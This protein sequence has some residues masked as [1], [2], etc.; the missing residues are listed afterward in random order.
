MDMK[1]A[2]Y[3]STTGL[4]V[5]T[6]FLAL[7]M[8]PTLVPRTA[9]LQG[10][11]SGGALAA[12]YGLG[13]LGEALWAYLELPSAPRRVWLKL[14][15]GAAVLCLIVTV[16]FMW[17]WSTWQGEVRA[18]VEM[19]PGDGFQP[20]TV[21]A[22]ALALFL[23][24]W[25]LG[26]K[27]KALWRRLSAKLGRFVPHKVSVVLGLLL[28]LYVFWLVVDGVLFS[29]LIRSADSSYRQV[30]A[31]IEADVPPPTDTLQAGSAASLL[32]WE[33]MG[34]EGRRYVAAEPRADSLEAFLGE[35]AAQPRR[36]Y[37]GMHVSDDVDVRAELAL[38]ELQRVGA[39]DRSVLV[40]IT[41]TGT[42]WVDPPSIETI[43]YLHRGEVASVAAQYS[44]L[45]SALALLMEGDH[46]AEMA[47]ALFR[48]V[49]GHWTTLPPDE[50]PA[51]YLNGLSLGALNSDRSFDFFDIINDPFQGALWVGPPF[52]QHTWRSVTDQREP[53]SPAWRP[54][55]RDGSVVR[56]MNQDGGLEEGRAP[57][58]PFRI[59]YLQYASD[60]I[61]FFDP[62]MLTQ[63][64]DWMQ[65]PRGPDV[66]DNLSWYPV[67][68]MLQ[69]A[70]DMLAGTSAPR[71]YGHEYAASH[72]IDAWYALTEPEGWT[73]AELDRLR[74][75]LATED[76]QA[77]RASYS[78]PSTP[79]FVPTAP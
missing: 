19:P 55:F 27:F 4:L 47:Q 66:S 72:Y 22:I 68:T 59:A 58:G 71:G 6:F 21:G 60:P 41:P 67:V 3:F 20:L 31:V 2:E 5:G 18:L 74:E 57:W 29:V 10:I 24:L 63:E 69:L 65:S 77:R 40:L 11:V 44:H 23:V 50:R 64:P 14:K 78:S 26:W 61:T 33:Q 30:D 62:M 32:D 42:G 49:Y 53:G 28:S 12:G 48:V 73:G 35:P 39:F 70:V 45:P 56:F 38:E 25:A 52:R 76:E 46:G 15:G 9:V 37:V 79:T 34:R 16:L 13:V 7:S 36:V 8:T 1:I 51:L 54:R 43:E 75:H 17:Q